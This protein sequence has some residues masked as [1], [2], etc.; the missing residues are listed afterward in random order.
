MKIRDRIKELRRVKASDLRPNPRN[1]RTHS[2]AQRDALQGLLTELGYCDALLA[3]E[4]PDGSL[5][6][7]DGHLRAETTPDMHVPVLVL[8]VTEEEADKLLATLDP[9]AGL[10]GAD[11]TVLNEL[12][13]RVETD[14]AAVQAMLDGL[15]SGTADEA[16]HAEKPELEISLELFERH[17][18]LVFLFENEFDD[19]WLQNIRRHRRTLRANKYHYLHAHG[20]APGGFVSMRTMQTEQAGVERMR[21]KWGALFRPGGSAG[22]K[23]ATGKNILNSFVRVPI[24]GC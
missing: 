10:A 8:D 13:D 23:S 22:G 2:P 1:W 7:C 16:E 19:F 20:K 12:L 15:R 24:P 4:L 11:D 17:D 6:L 18:Y 21:Q 9:L 5:E 3:R 14:S